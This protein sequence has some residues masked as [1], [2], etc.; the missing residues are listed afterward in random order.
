MKTL[1]QH[2]SL[3][4]VALQDHKAG[5]RA[6]N[7]LFQFLWYSSIISSSFQFNV[8]GRSEGISCK[9]LQATLE[10]QQ[11]Q[12]LICMLRL[13]QSAQLKHSLQKL[14]VTPRRSKWAGRG[15]AMH[16]R[17]ALTPFKSIYN[18]NLLL[19]DIIIC[20]AP[21]VYKEREAG[22]CCKELTVKIDCTV[23]LILGQQWHHIHYKWW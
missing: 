19:L 4:K 20:M 16:G 15:H 23:A 21:S 17:T 22:P 13:L 10:T 3:N 9:A 8:L 12:W 14:A 11:R 5:H 18:C 7:P 2:P 6:S 1:A